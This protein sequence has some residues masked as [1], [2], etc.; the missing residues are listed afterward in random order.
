V[1]G[2]GVIQG[3]QHKATFAGN[4]NTLDGAAVNVEMP[5]GTHLVLQTIGIALTDNQNSVFV[6]EIKDSPGVL[7]GDNKIVYEDAFDSIQADIQI[8]SSLAGIESDVILKEKIDR[9]TIQAYGIDPASAR[10]QVWHQVLQAPDATKHIN[11]IKR[12]SGRVDLNENVAFQKM[13]ISQGSAFLKV[14]N[15]QPLTDSV[16]IENGIPV[17]KEYTHIEGFDFLIESL[18]FIDVENDLNQLPAPQEAR[19][20]NKEAIEKAFASRQGSD[21]KRPVSLAR[22]DSDK[23]KD[24]AV[25]MLTR[26]VLNPAEGKSFVLDYVVLNSSLTNYVFK[27]D[28]TYYITNV[29]DLYGT[30][31]LEGGAVIKFTNYTSL[32]PWLKIR[33]GFDCRTSPYN[34]A[35]FTAKDDDSVGETISGSTGTPSGL[36]ALYNLQFVSMNNV[37]VHDI[38]SRYSFNGVGFYTGTNHQAW[39]LQVFNCNRGIEMNTGQL[40]VQNALLYKTAYA[41][42]VPGNSVTTINAEHLTIRSAD[43]LFN[44]ASGQ[45]NTLNLTNCL[46]VGVTNGS[47]SGVYS[48]YVV[49]A[50]SDTGIFS[51]KGIA[52]NYL[53]SSSPYRDAGTTNLSARMKSILKTT[54]TEPPQEITADFTSDTTLYPVV[55]RDTDIPDLGYHYQPLDYIWITRGVDLNKTLIL[56]NGVAVGVGG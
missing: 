4:A 22:K 9:A 19:V 41:F 18:P 23:P 52:T 37:Q 3:A 29:V 2:K 42:L 47:L 5:D 16:S 31:V 12:N 45:T 39:N 28:S 38:Q 26:G 8:T 48:N 7:I 15:K 56:S 27:G 46:V 34:P 1:N 49:S 55:A 51:G 50:A 54:T 36:Y 53:A 30:T 35:F 44:Y 6:A 11:L 32:S 14:S 17:A 25:A 24:K 40:D 20:I 13:R 43:M 33:E 21:R 10:L